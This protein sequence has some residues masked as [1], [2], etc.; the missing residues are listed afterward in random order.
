[1]ELKKEKYLEYFEKSE[2]LLKAADHMI[3][4]TFPLIKENRLLKKI[5]ENIGE[6]AL[7]IIM[8]VLEHEQLYKRAD[9]SQDLKVNIEVFKRCSRR[10]NITA[11]ETE[12]IL[13]VLEISE[14]HRES[15]FEFIRKDK[16]VMMSDNLK[17]ESIDLE[18]L[19]R[20]MNI[21]KSI[22][23]KVK[24]IYDE[25]KEY[26]FSQRSKFRQ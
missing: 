2:A 24:A 9:I 17:T 16:L 10:F 1:M 11:E 26:E 25:K 23:F 13:K 5:I 8:S 20:Y 4:I 14:K 15:P 18:Q 19:K 7:N 22:M 3:Y 12:T 6:G 21:I